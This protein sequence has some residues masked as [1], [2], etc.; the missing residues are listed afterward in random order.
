MTG[1]VISWVILTT[2][3]ISF[4]VSL[5][6]SMMML[7]HLRGGNREL[8]K[9]VMLGPFSSRELFTELGWRHRNRAVR[10]ALLALFLFTVWAFQFIRNP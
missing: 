5:V 6:S 7:A 9:V 1:S 8:L 10:G 3:I 4:A 2:A